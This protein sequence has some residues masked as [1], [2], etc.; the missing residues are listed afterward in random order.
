MLC[1]SRQRAKQ[2]AAAQPR[3]VKMLTYLSHF[4][5]GEVDPGWPHGILLSATVLASFA[6]AAG[7]LLERP[8][9]SESVHR[10]ATWLVLSG[11]AVEAFCTIVLFVFDE[12]ISNAQQ[13][14]I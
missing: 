3:M 13:D 5:S 11:V 6:V 7:I 14:K 4:F 2:A 10:V 8:K 12:G 9:Y 1:A